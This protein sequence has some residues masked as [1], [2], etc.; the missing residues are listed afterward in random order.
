MIHATAIV[1]PSAKL[2]DDVQVGPYSIIGEDVELDSGCVVESHVVIK[3]PTKIGKNNRFFQFSSIGEECQDKKYAG[4]R[5]HLEIGDNNVF[6]E[7]VT[8]HRGTIQDQ[9][10]T[11]IGSN[12]LL[13]AY[14]HVAHDCVIGNDN[15]LANNATLAGHVHVGNCVILGGTTAVHQFCHIGSHSFT[16]GGCIVLRDIPPFV[17]VNGI[18]HTPAGINAEGLRRRG[19]DKDVIMDIK[20]AYKVLYRSGNR[21]EEAVEE[22]RKM[23]ETTKEVG[24]MAEFVASSKRGIIR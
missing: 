24:M 22:L 23:A 14:V 2:A 19:F 17:M 18:D 5:T 9:S 10:L 6:R 21:A 7:C 1:H 12:N 4:E 3:G 15:I 16:G 13:M 20:R 8:V 11:Q